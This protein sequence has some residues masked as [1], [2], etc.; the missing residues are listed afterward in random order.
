MLTV[1]FEVAGIHAGSRILDIGCGSGRHSFAAMRRGAEVVSADAALGELDEVRATSRAM[2]AAGEIDCVNRGTV[3]T[4]ICAMPFAGASFDVVIASE[5]LEHV[6]ADA[7]AIAECGRV[8]KPGGMLVVTVPRTLPEAVNWL[9]SRRY[10]D[11]PGGH[12]R[13]YRRSQLLSR[14]S[15]AG[16]CEVRRAYRHG[17]H[18]PYWWLRCA[19]GVD[20]PDRRAVALYHRLLVYEIVHAPRSLKALGRVLDPLIGKSA[21]YYVTID[22]PAAH[23][24]AG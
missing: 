24:V 7:A 11:R 22:E 10:H 3:A 21:V 14:L 9:L 17:L 23:R 18:S 20:R 5:I 15:C 6:R 19:L 13:I 1:D 4:D 2:E 8:L 16:F 12:V